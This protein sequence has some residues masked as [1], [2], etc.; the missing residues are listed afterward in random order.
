[1]SASIAAHRSAVALVDAALSAELDDPPSL[2]AVRLLALAC[3]DSLRPALESTHA[4]ALALG[5]DPLALCELLEP[6]SQKHLAPAAHH[7]TK[8]ARHEGPETP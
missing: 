5:A 6:L 1:M 8:D 4:L 7:P 3:A 2:E